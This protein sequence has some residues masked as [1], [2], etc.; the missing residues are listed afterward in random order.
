MAQL[1]QE[2]PQPPGMFMSF[3]CAD[4]YWKQMLQYLAKHMIAVEPKGTYADDKPP[5]LLLSA[6][7][8]QPAPSLAPSSAQPLPHSA[9]A[10][11][12][13]MRPHSMYRTAHHTLFESYSSLRCWSR[14]VPL[15]SIARRARLFS[16]P[17]H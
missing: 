16:R 17:A 5:D 8:I 7:S 11:H 13:S 3:S 6:A 2:K 12:P 1:Q 10:S 4:F 14:S 9:H 15:V